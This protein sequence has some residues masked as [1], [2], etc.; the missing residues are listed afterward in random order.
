MYYLS[1]R[2]LKHKNTLKKRISQINNMIEHRNFYPDKILFGV[3][4]SKKNQTSI[5]IVKEDAE[6]P[7]PNKCEKLDID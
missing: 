4:K 5:W 3:C 2:N 1:Q 6:I 7:K